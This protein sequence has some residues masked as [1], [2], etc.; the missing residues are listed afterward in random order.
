VQL[1]LLPGPSQG[2]PVCFADQ[3]RSQ[4]PWPIRRGTV[5]STALQ[6]Q[7]CSKNAYMNADLQL[8]QLCTAD[9]QLG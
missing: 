2:L 5:R 6:L 3:S 4:H 7:Y 8:G 1:I 9:L